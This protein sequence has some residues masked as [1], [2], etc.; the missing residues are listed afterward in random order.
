MEGSVVL[1]F[2]I[3]G[4]IALVKKYLPKLPSEGWMLIAIILGGVAGYFGLFVDGVE[5]GTGIGAASVGAYQVAK[6]AGG[7]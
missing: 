6:R 5:L 3:T 4:V 2:A 7:Q 1:G